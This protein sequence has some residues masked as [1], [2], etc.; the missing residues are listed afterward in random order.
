[1][2][3]GTSVS[4][5]AAVLLSISRKLVLFV[6]TLFL[7]LILQKSQNKVGE[8]MKTKPQKFLPVLLPIVVQSPSFLS[9]TEQTHHYMFPRG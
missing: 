4:H 3:T 6:S 2:C 8:S 7:L 5:A 9:L 1:M